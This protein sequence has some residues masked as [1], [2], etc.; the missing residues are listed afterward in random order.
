LPAAENLE[1]LPRLARDFGGGRLLQGS[2]MN[3]SRLSWAEPEFNLWSG[4]TAGPLPFH[5]PA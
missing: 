5:Q 3:V 2:V 4:I 1:Q